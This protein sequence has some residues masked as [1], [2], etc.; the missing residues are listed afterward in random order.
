MV[1][2]PAGKQAILVTYSQYVV[3]SHTYQV[4][5]FR[6]EGRRPIGDASWWATVFDTARKVGNWR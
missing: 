4:R 2:H 5:E 6:T 1:L 3:M